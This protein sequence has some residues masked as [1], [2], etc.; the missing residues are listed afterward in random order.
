MRM[1]RD[2]RR[3]HYAI[4]DVLNTDVFACLND[5]GPAAGSRC[6]TVDRKGYNFEQDFYGVIPSNLAMGTP[7]G[8]DLTLLG[9]AD[10]LLEMVRGL[11]GLE[12]DEDS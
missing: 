5:R 12:Q 4:E 8:L 2:C 7:G 10:E 3:C 6:F 9:N 11:Y 1:S